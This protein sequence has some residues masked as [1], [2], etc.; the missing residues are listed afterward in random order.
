MHGYKYFEFF[1]ALTEAVVHISFQNN[2]IALRW[3]K[4]SFNQTAVFIFSEIKNYEIFETLLILM[5]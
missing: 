5:H 4:K 1:M 2:S 3:K